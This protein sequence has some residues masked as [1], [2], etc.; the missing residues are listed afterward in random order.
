MVYGV[1]LVGLTGLLV[2]CRAFTGQWL[3]VSVTP[4]SCATSKCFG[5]SRL[6]TDSTPESSKALQVQT[7]SRISRVAAG[8]LVSLSTIQSAQAKTVTEDDFIQAL[9]TMIVCKKVISPTKDY[10]TVAAYDAAR[11]NI[12]YVLNQLQL[13][14]SVT[15]LMQNSIDFNDDM[16]AIEAAQ[17]AGNSIANTAIQFDSTVYTCVFIPSDD[18][19]VPP[20]AVKYRK[21]AND[22]Y[23]TLN[24]DFDA[25]LKVGSEAQLAK[26]KVIADKRIAELPQVLFKDLSNLRVTGI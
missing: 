20:S 7:L 13:Q 23:T 14:K 1:L 11:S 15:T 12:Q 19:T 21:Q 25:L 8:I 22:F 6:S 26:A 9:S 3:A 24:E 5:H 10:V 17:E 16:D 18:G 4:I 2:S